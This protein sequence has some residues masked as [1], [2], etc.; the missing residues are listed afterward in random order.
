MNMVYLVDNHFG[1][2]PCNRPILT[3][4]LFWY[5][6]LPAEQIEA[7]YLAV[8]RYMFSRGQFELARP[9]DVTLVDK[10]QVCM[11]MLFN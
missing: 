3:V 4:L 1:F 10:D 11:S 9:S 2:P 7:Q 6:W 8:K 5:C